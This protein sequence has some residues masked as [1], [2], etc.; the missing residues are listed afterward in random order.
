MVAVAATKKTIEFSCLLLAGNLG[1]A[2][3][4]IG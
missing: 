2:H 3:N 4:V 1:Y